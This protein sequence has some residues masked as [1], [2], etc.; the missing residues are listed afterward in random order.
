MLANP[1]QMCKRKSCV[2]QVPLSK[3]ADSALVLSILL[4]NE[5]GHPRNIKTHL[6]TTHFISTLDQ[7]RVLWSRGISQR[8][9]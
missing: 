5:D 6:A 8:R 7:D 9:Q 2:P 3:S 1:I 4:L